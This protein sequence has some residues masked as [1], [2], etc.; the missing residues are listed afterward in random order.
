MSENPSSRPPN[1]RWNF[2]ALLVD[3]ASFMLGLAFLNLNSVLPAFVQRFSDSAPLMGLVSTVWQGCWLL[4]QLPVA[5]LINDKPLKKPFMLT[6]SF[7]GR[8]ILLALPVALWAGLGRYSTATLVLFFVCLG[9]FAAGDGTGSLA[10]FDIVAKTIPS[11]LRGRLFG[12]A[13]VVSGL[14]GIGIGALLGLILSH[15]KLPF[16]SN[17]ALVFTLANIVIIPSTV[18]LIALREPPG[19]VRDLAGE[20]PPR[21]QWL[22]TLTSDKTFQLFVLSRIL[23]GMGSLAVPFYVRH[24]TSVL[25][26]PATI[27]GAF[28]TAQTVG[29][30]GVSAMVSLTSRH[31][32]PHRVAR[33]GSAVA[34]IAPAMAL[35][36]QVTRSPVLIQ[37]Y[38]LVF[39]VIGITHSAT[40]LGFFNYLMEIAPER[41]RPAYAGLSNTI[42]GLLMV[43]PTLGGWLLEVTSYSALF[44]ITAA[45]L[46]LGFFLTLKL[47]PTESAI[48]DVPTSQPC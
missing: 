14:G 21:G 22:K 18:A 38:P 5:H 32:R 27:V 16:P 25:E 48:A 44:I 3:Y 36:I 20:T 39:A 12:W 23:F 17:Y 6:V 33:L 47:E 8:V 41:T 24:A 45:L 28:V 37:L 40:T 15:P 35:A 2:I 7:T 10:W 29:S 30:V 46:V 4:P 9:C 43:V 1:L 13:Q 19:I 11:R 31:W 42:L 34:V 26:L